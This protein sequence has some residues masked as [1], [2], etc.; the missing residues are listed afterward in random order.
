ML[1]WFLLRDEP[2]LAGWQSGLI[3]AR[4]QRKPAF[5]AFQR[6]AAAVR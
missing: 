5:Y 6:L 1:L 3:T 4:G 2:R